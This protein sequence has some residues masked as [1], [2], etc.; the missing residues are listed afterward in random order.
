M[1][2]AVSKRIGR[3]RGRGAVINQIAE[4]SGASSVT[5]RTYLEDGRVHTPARRAIAV[6]VDDLPAEDLAVLMKQSS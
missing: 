6:A 5:V 2:T 1:T 3:P 4:I